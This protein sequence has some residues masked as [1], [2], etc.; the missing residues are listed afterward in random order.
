MHAERQTVLRTII[1]MIMFIQL[2][3]V[4]ILIMTTFRG[5]QMQTLLSKYTKHILQ[6]SPW[7]K[8]TSEKFFFHAVG[9]CHGLVS[10]LVHCNIDS[11]LWFSHKN[12]QTLH[13]AVFHLI[14]QSKEVTFIIRG[15]EPI[16]TK[17]WIYLQIQ[18]LEIRASI[19]DSE[20][21]D[22]LSCVVPQLIVDRFL[23][24][25]HHQRVEQMLSTM[26][27]LQRLKAWV[28]SEIWR[29]TWSSNMELT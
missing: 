3:Q 16:M 19:K 14:G 6:S 22:R 24:S 12:R 27:K 21:T 11:S 29:L 8:Q 20:Y 25:M 1:S 15:H 10:V 17:P 9:F 4:T 7:Q 18:K 26:H 5:T 28:L 23:L 2:F 13:S